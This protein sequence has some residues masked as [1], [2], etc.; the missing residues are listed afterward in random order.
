M[1]ATAAPGEAP[2]SMGNRGLVTGRAK[3][4]A[5]AQKRYPPRVDVNDADKAD[6]TEEGGE[7]ADPRGAR[8]NRGRG[9]PT[10][11]G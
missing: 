2:P 9:A 4:L 1:P 3:A 7:T 8:P 5:T 6:Y 11:P 10:R